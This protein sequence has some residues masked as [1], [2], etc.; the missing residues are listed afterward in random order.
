MQHFVV[1]RVRHGLSIFLAVLFSGY[2]L[3]T[4]SCLHTHTVNAHTVTHAHPYQSPQ[5]THS[6][7]DLSGFCYSNVIET[8]LPDVIGDIDVDCLFLREVFQ[9]VVSA[10]PFCP[11]RH[12]GLRAPPV[13]FF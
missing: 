4:S 2:M 7:P 1:N 3:W 12:I 6:W 9:F 8:V 5:H 13:M 11:V 10:C